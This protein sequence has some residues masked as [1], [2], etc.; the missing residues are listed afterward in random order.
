MSLIIG[1]MKKIRETFVAVIFTLILI[2]ATHAAPSEQG[3]LN[4]YADDDG[5][6]FSNY[7]EQ[8]FG[9]D[10]ADASSRPSLAD[11]HDLIKGSWPLIENAAD[12]FGSGIEG[13]LKG[14]A[15]FKNGALKLDGKEAYVD[16]GNSSIL[17]ST[18][19]IA[20]SIWIRPE[21]L[22]LSRVL[23]KYSKKGSRMEY[24]CF[25]LGGRVWV[26]ISDDGT[27]KCGHSILGVTKESV[28]KNKRWA[29][30]A[31]NWEAGG[32]IDIYIDGDQVRTL[33]IGSSLLSKMHAGNADLTLGSYDIE[34]RSVGRG[35]KIIRK[36]LNAFKGSVAGFTL[37]EGG[38]TET[39]A[40]EIYGLG[41]KGDLQAYV[42]MDFD[43]DGMADWWERLYFGDLSEDAQGDADADGI[44]NLD[45]FLQGT[46]PGSGDDGGG[47]VIRVNC[48]T[49]SDSNDG[50]ILP[51]ATIG[52]GVQK[53]VDGDI[54]EVA[55]GTYNELP[56]V[57]DL[58]GKSLTLRTTGPVFVD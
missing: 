28:L 32:L 46:D 52:A 26:F 47:G 15:G 24:A 33:N 37:L 9:T 50:R 56:A 27:A 45:E 40:R 2:G 8:L 4:R 5:D 39:E 18:N 22:G 23:G 48:I 19:G 25:L 11:N 51:L 14:G 38:L 12:V 42:D 6:G 49:G 29:H 58:T 53:A 3:S 43:G 1:G 21:N 7:I 57:Y 44:T 54:I 36:V 17:S 20:W 34:E 30:L 31:V 55:S 41:R 35:R 10:P 13:E 16:F